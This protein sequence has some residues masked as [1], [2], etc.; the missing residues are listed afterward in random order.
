MKGQIEPRESGA[1]DL[2]NGLLRKPRLASRAVCSEIRVWGKSLRLFRSALRALKL[3]ACNGA[4]ESGRGRALS[5]WASSEKG[6][7]GGA[8]RSNHSTKHWEEKERDGGRGKK[9]QARFAAR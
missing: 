6:S 5:V 7:W 2:G 9:T 8:M 3:A 4:A 1:S